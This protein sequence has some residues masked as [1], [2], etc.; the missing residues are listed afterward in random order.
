MVLQ[1]HFVRIDG[2]KFREK[3]EDKELIGTVRNNLKNNQTNKAI[4]IYELL[5]AFTSGQTIMTARF[6]TE[7]SKALSTSLVLID[8]DDESGTIQLDTML[9]LFRGRLSAFYYS[10]SQADYNTRLRL[11]FQLQKDVTRGVHRKIAQKLIKEIEN[12]Y[13]NLDIGKHI[14][15]KASTQLDRMWFGTNKGGA[16]VDD[17]ARISEMFI[18]RCAKEVKEDIKKKLEKAPRIR[19]RERL[20]YKGG[21]IPFEDLEAMAKAIGGIVSGTSVDWFNGEVVSSYEA[22]S[23]LILAIRGHEMNGYI[24]YNEAY[25]LAEIISGDG[26]STKEFDKFSPRNE[27]TIATFIKLAVERGYHFNNSFN[28]DTKEFNLPAVPVEAENGKYVPKD[29]MKE[30]LQEPQRTLVEAPTGSGKTYATVEAMKELANIKDGLMYVIALPT[31]ALARQVAKERNIPLIIGGVNSKPSEIK[32]LWITGKRVFAAVYDQVKNI[33]ENTNSTEL[34]LV[35][36]EVHKLTTDRHYRH[37]TIQE[38]IDTSKHARTFI[39]ITGTAEDVLECDLFDVK[40]TVKAIND[41]P[42]GSFHI[43]TYTTQVNGKTEKSI[44]LLSLVKLIGE[45]YKK[46]G[47]KSL[48]FINNKELIEETAAML[49]DEYEGI[50]I[51]EVYR[52]ETQK[53]S[54]EY[55]RVVNNELEGI[56][57]ILATKIIA[58][59]I[60]LSFDTIDWNIIVLSDNRTR[61]FNPSE[62]RQMFHRI[63]TAYRNAILIIREP[64]RTNEEAKRFHKGRHLKVMYNRAKMMKDYFNEDPD[65][66]VKEDDFLKLDQLEQEYGLYID[67]EGLDIDKNVLNSEVVREKERYYSSEEHR[68]IFTEEVSRVLQMKPNVFSFNDILEKEVLEMFDI[69][70]DEEIT[71][72]MQVE[73][74]K[75]FYSPSIHMALRKGDIESVFG[76]NEKNKKKIGELCGRAR[77]HAAVDFARGIQDY[78]KAKNNLLNVTRNNERNEFKERLIM[79]NVKYKWEMRKRRSFTQQ[80]HDDI[81]R[82]VEGKEFTRS[83]LQEL[84]KNFAIEKN[85][86]IKDIETVFKHFT[87]FKR[88]GGKRRSYYSFTAF[89]L[90]EEAERYMLSV[91]EFNEAAMTVLTEKEMDKFIKMYEVKKAS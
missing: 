64:T 17:Q 75:K 90:K 56:D 31:R 32:E 80:V 34:V 25:Q 1:K 86:K 35:V 58:D 60:S 84:K 11:I 50:N 87:T 44:E 21:E 83:D 15:V 33:M 7:F 82:V 52:D 61:T 41:V 14:D 18:N 38:L 20:N 36:D 57:V 24:S 88:V 39:G 9:Q 28:T 67:D 72:E 70:E 65:I 40:Y 81:L 55:Q 49:K 23:S 19:R 4:N 68:V 62:V 42:A 45:E 47:R 76:E 79:R 22:W 54:E 59:G 13:P 37:D 66:D 53:D 8:I 2:N 12:K 51:L 30:I 48:V 89:D 77:V 73:N 91:K 29:F 43:M 26:L 63:R 27:I 3:P 46:G 85:L 71:P 5:N 78:E 6:D 10:F 74:F 16:I 69:E